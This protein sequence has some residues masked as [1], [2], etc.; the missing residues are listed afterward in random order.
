MAT[1]HVQTPAVLSGK[2]GLLE[3][4]KCDGYV[5]RKRNETNKHKTPSGNGNM[6]SKREFR[7]KYKR[8]RHRI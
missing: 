4:L 5:I 1:T 3:R 7:L 6:I 2:G 8:N